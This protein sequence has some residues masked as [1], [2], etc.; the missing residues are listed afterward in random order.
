[1][2]LLNKRTFINDMDCFGDEIMSEIETNQGMM[3]NE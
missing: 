2:Y 1:M 3:I